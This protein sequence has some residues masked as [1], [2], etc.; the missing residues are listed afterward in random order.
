MKKNS[1]V[2]KM[3]TMKPL[4][5]VEKKWY[6]SFWRC[7]LSSKQSDMGQ[8]QCVCSTHTPIPLSK[9]QYQSI[10]PTFVIMSNVYN[11]DVCCMFEQ[12]NVEKLLFL[13]RSSG[14][15]MWKGL[16]GTQLDHDA[17]ACVYV[18]LTSVCLTDLHIFGLLWFINTE[19][20]KINML[21]NELLKTAFITVWAQ[22]YLY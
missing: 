3:A 6:K 9:N 7:W 14:L 8:W 21:F 2:Y 1:D 13:W 18:V 22:L 17:A 4:P 19:D 5:V 20:G 16:W 10:F 12:T 15:H 11:S